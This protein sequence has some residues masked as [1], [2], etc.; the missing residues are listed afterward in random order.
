MLRAP[1]ATT[2]S[3]MTDAVGATKTS[4][5]TSGSTP[6]NAWS[7][8]SGRSSLPDLFERRAAR[9]AEPLL[10]HQPRPELAD[11]LDIL[12]AAPDARHAAF[13]VSR[14]SSRRSRLFHSVHGRS[15]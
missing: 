1:P 7:G 11:A 6:S 12:R 3:P 8:I 14:L 4:S 9:A 5:A 10:R 13:V 2:T 15:G